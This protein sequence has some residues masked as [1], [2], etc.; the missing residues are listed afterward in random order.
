[1]TSPQL[2][3]HVIRHAE[4][5]LNSK[6]LVTGGLDP[7]LSIRG[8]EQA[9][10]LALKLD[11]HYDLYV[12][13]TL[14]RARKTIEIATGKTR[15]DIIYEPGLN[16]IGLGVLEGK[17]KELIK[18]YSEGNLDYAPPG[19]ESYREL[20]SRVLETLSHLYTYAVSENHRKILICTHAGPMRILYGTLG[21]CAPLY[22]AQQV[23]SLKFEN[24]EIVK[25]TCSSRDFDPPFLWI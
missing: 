14:L 5:A 7:N 25:L 3:I 24:T 11:P 13:S 12:T 22:T 20:A 23:L 19:G 4:S 6:G 16:E 1:M 2:E 9:K 15:A 18:E 10:N 17:P 8:V 21:L